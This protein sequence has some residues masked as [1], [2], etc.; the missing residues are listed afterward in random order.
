MATKRKPETSEEPTHFEDAIARLGEIVESLEGGDL[1]LEQ[2][3][4]LFEEGVRL[5]RSAQTTLGNAERRVE[6]LLSIADGEPVLR[7][8]DDDDAADD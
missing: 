7:T 6:E 3:L 4:K 8:L 5:A 2:S 1:P